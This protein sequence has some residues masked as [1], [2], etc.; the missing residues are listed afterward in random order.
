LPFY[1]E[2]LFMSEFM[3]EH[4]T[5]GALRATAAA[6]KER[7]ANDGDAED[8]VRHEGNVEQKG[9]DAVDFVAEAPDRRN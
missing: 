2:A 9:V 3:R 1:L 6:G 7:R 4:P 8:D 5:D